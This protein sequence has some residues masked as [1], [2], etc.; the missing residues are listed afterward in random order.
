MWLSRG[1]SSGYLSTKTV[2]RTI[3]RLA[4]EAGIQEEDDAPHPQA[5]SCCKC[6][7]G[8]R[9]GADDPEA[10]GAQEAVHDVDL[11]YDGA[12]AGIAT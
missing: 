5:Q 9:A 8:S 3:D 12:G 7:G 6:A 2:L 10:G 1:R 4:E 11:C